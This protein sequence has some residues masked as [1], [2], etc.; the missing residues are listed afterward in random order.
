MNLLRRAGFYIRY[1]FTARSIQYIHSPFLF[2]LMQDVFSTSQNPEFAGI[3][4]VRQSLLRNS[5]ET[6]VEDMGAGSRISGKKNVRKISTIAR[7]SLQRPKYAQF[8]YRLAVHLKARYCIELG[9]SLGVTTQYLSAAAG[10]DGKV[11][12]LEG[13]SAIARLA[14]GSFR[15]AGRN[16]IRMVKG[17]FDITFGEALRSL[18]RVDL[19]FIDGNHRRGPTLRYFREALPYLHSGSVIIF[20]DIYWSEEM[21][22]AWKEIYQSPEIT[23]S[24]ELFQ[25]GV[26]FFNPD[27]SKE[28]F[29]LRY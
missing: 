5:L 11:V 24:F 3:E 29:R 4:K 23:L 27:L 20:D 2:S 14:E 21:R 10:T 26:V 7:T 8:L 22:S 13:S 1:R 17:N 9:T 6:E 19:L 28:H 18:P 15:E 12:T 16:N 25:F